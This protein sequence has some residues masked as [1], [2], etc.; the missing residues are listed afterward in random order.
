MDEERK[1]D[2]YSHF[3]L[4][5]AFSATEDLRRRFTRL[6]SQLFRI[7]FQSNDTRD[8]QDF[9]NGLNFE[10]E[11]VSDDEKRE[12]STELA[13]VSSGLKKGEEDGWFKVDW[14]K[15]PE[16]VES[17][18]VFLKRGKAYVPTREQMSMV[19]SEFSKRLEQ[20]L[21]VRLIKSRL[22]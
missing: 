3:T 4:R 13:A 10:W 9:V 20:A 6:E 12:L 17:R 15:V 18:R 1:R 19:M 22:T 5:L 14:E 2:H 21:E 8:R 11:R 16:L 7:R